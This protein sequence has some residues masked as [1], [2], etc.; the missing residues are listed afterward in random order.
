[1]SRGFSFPTFLQLHKAQN[2]NTYVSFFFIIHNLVIQLSVF[3]GIYRFSSLFLTK[4]TGQKAFSILAT[5][6][7]INTEIHLTFE[8]NYMS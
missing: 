6:M 5:F 7:A 8:I 2:H 1:M 3:P 4:E